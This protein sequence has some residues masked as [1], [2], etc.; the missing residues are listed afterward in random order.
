MRPPSSPDRSGRLTL[1]G[2]VHRRPE[3]AE[4]LQALLQTLHP[5]EL[6]LEMSPYAVH[7][8]LGTAPRLLLR[9]ERILAR[10]SASEGIAPSDL[11][12]H[13]E[14]RGIRALLAFP[15]EFCAAARYAAPRG[16]PL[17]L[18]DLSTISARKLCRVEK[19]LVTFRNLK[20]LTTLPE[21]PEAVEGY[22]TAR[23]LLTADPLLVRAFLAGRRGREGIGMRDRWMERALRRRL[24]QRPGIHLVHIGG[25]VHLLEDPQK[26]TLFSRLE[27]LRPMRR[28]VDSG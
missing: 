23:R 26:Q 19:E 9:L 4:A 16:I 11:E 25:W 7:W 13:P 18:V 28:V 10:L 2:I 14:V 20:V 24:R 1:V 22:A 6:T 21:P 5:D 17:H 15:E 27:D 8:R 3:T 12:N